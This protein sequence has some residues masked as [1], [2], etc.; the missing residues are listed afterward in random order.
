M[1]V[2]HLGEAL[3][4]WVYRLDYMHA[5]TVRSRRHAAVKPLALKP[6]EYLRRNIWITTSG[7][8]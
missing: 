8:A 1:V 5:A 6:S 2:G 4:F 7:M 3:P